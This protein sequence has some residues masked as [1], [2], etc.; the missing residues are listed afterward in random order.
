MTEIAVFYVAGNL[1][2]KWS[3]IYTFPTCRLTL[4]KFRI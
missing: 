4:N 2:L 1:K 3:V